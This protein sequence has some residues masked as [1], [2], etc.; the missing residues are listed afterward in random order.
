MTLKLHDIEKEDTGGGVSETLPA[1]TLSDA[2][3][4]L[5]QDFL[6]RAREPQVPAAT[7]DL[8]S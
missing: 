5:V 6:K 2:D 1:R 4:A 3:E 8:F 7:G